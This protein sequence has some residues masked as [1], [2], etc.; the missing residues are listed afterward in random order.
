[1]LA[2][3]GRWQVQPLSFRSDVGL[4][5]LGDDKRVML[6]NCLV[7]L[8]AYGAWQVQLSSFGGNVGLVVMGDDR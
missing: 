3:N 5:G 8:V 4:V 1:M 2:A 6:R 7:V